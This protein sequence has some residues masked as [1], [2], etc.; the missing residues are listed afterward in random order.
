M[1]RRE[2]QLYDDIVKIFNMQF[3][4]RFAKAPDREVG[5]EWVC[6]V[7]GAICEPQRNVN[8]DERGKLCRSQCTSERGRT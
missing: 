3:Y 5:E 2:Q 1:H 6:N 4:H 7:E 8:D